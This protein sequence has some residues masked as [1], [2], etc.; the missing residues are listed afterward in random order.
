[1]ETLSGQPDH[2]YSESRRR[3]LKT[4]AA[5]TVGVTVWSEPTIKGLARRPAFAAVASSPRFLQPGDYSVNN[6]PLAMVGAVTFS[7][8]QFGTQ[9]R[10]QVSADG[11]TCSYDN[12]AAGDA[13]LID[14]FGFE[15]QPGTLVFPD[16]LSF[17]FSDFA[18]P[19][20][21]RVVNSLS[22]SCV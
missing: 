10:L 6:S 20:N 14:D 13:L 21:V 5:A 17:E 18:A 7:F 8:F 2:P 3:L 19:A 15:M 12:Y 16:T 9:Y 1:M 11:C 22:V 4:A